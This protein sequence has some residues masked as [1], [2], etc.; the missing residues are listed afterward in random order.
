MYTD[1][2]RCHLFVWALAGYSLEWLLRDLDCVPWMRP[3]AQA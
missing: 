2:I 1:A 3:A